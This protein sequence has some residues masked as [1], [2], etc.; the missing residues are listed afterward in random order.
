MLWYVRCSTAL[1]HSIDPMT[2]IRQ[3]CQVLVQMGCSQ[4]V[5]QLMQE[6]HAIAQGQFTGMQFTDE[7]KRK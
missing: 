1:I 4:D 3:Q 5:N 7:G 2:A 6:M